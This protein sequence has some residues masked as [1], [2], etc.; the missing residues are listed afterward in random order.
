MVTKCVRS[1]LGDLI[2]IGQH[3]T[4]RQMDR[5]AEQP[6]SAK[7]YGIGYGRPPE[8]ANDPPRIES[9]KPTTLKEQMMQSIRCDLKGIEGTTAYVRE[10]ASHKADRNYEKDIA[11]D[12]RIG[13]MSENPD[14]KG[15]ENAQGTGGSNQYKSRQAGS[16][17]N[18]ER[19]C[20]RWPVHGTCIIPPC[21]LVG[22]SRMALRPGPSWDSP[23]ILRCSCYPALQQR[24]GK[25]P[26]RPGRRTP[27]RRYPSPPTSSARHIHTWRP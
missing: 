24:G 18:T 23:M 2:A 4:G 25:R 11:Q 13:L 12:G 21:V 16:E 26:H 6:P 22:I 14:C 10:K 27:H 1:A 5:E 3:P 9:V 17:P 15:Q 19:R 8:T 7:P 20:Q